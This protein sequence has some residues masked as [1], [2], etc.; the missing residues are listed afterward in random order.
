MQGPNEPYDR[1]QVT[2][3]NLSRYLT[4]PE[5]SGFLRE[6]GVPIAEATLRRMVSQHRVP[7]TKLSKRVVFS[8]FRLLEWL[9]SKAVEPSA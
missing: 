8:A 3:E 7:F 4:Y 9:E 2:T 5:A 1:A 6:R